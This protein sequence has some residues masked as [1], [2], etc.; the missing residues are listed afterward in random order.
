MSPSEG[1]KSRAVSRAGRGL[2]GLVPEECCRLASDCLALVFIG[3]GV[4][5]VGASWCGFEK[6]KAAELVTRR[7]GLEPLHCIRAV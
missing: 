1:R 7:H 6:K 4:E 2:C 5:N 3:R